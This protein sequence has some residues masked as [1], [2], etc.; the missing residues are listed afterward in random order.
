MQE[1]TALRAAAAQRIPLPDPRVQ[2]VQLL[3]KM[4]SHDDVEAFLQMFE[5]TATREGWEREDWARLLAPLLTGE[6]Q[7]AYFALPTTTADQYDELKKEILARMGLSPVCAAQH[8]HEWEY[9]P[10]LAAHAQAA[11]LSRLAQHWLLDGNPTAT[12]VAERVVIDRLLCALPR[13]HRQAVGMRNPTTTTEL[14]E[15]IELA[16]AA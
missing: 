10:R 15:A 11:E 12:Q 7:W 13:S 8:F 16:E 2:A 3:P 14:V 5:N 1:L 4:T 9:K 6:A